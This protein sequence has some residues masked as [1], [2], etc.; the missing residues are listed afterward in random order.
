[1]ELVG[2]VIISSTTKKLPNLNRAKPEPAT[3]IITPP[4]AGSLEEA[5][6]TARVVGF[7]GAFGVRCDQIEQLIHS[8][9]WWES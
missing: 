5:A 8:A 7:P 4:P 2:E 9:L 3:A 1:V 6:E